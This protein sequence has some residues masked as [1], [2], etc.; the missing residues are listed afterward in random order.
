MG[1]TTCNASTIHGLSVGSEYTPAEVAFIRAMEQYQK[2]TRRRY[3]S[4][5]EVLRVAESLGYRRVT[6]CDQPKIGPT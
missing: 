2:R 4:F 1:M 5:V 3:P 6:P